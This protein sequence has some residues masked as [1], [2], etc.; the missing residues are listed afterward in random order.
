MYNYIGISLS[1]CM[2]FS[3]LTKVIFNWKAAIPMSMDKWS[4]TDV[5][6]A[7]INLFCNFALQLINK[8]AI[9]EGGK[10]PF[11][12]LMLLIVIITWYRM[13]MIAYVN[14]KLAVLLMTIEKMMTAGMNFFI[15]LI[16]Y[17]LIMAMVF[18][19]IFGD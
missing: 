6:C 13:M 12:L 10:L 18:L 4:T 11:N 3:V 9:L 7:T 8:K 14:E 15:M 5:I 17:F 16:Y 2:M 1:V 19:A